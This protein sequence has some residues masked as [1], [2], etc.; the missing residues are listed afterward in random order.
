MSIEDKIQE[1][2]AA[3][4]SLRDAVLQL[5]KCVVPAVT[6]AAAPATPLPAATPVAPA[7]TQTVTPVAPEAPVA[8]KP[9]DLATLRTSLKTDLKDLY[10]RNAAA[11]KAILDKFGVK[12]LS[13][14]SDDQLPVLAK[15][16]HEALTGA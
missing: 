14:L 7:P 1:N 10:T 11:G 15:A 2:T 13:E 3:L 12:N 9:V 5:A 6:Q 16:V 4:L 8:S